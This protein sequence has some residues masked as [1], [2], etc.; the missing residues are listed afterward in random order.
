MDKTLKHIK[1]TQTRKKN[2][3]SLTGAQNKEK[4]DKIHNIEGN[5]GRGG[6]GGGCGGSLVVWQSFV[7]SDQNE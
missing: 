5:W 4:T 7:T 6:R 2:A 3:Y 1:N